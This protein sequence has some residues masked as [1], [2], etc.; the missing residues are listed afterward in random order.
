MPGSNDI[1]SNWF[2][3]GSIAYGPEYGSIAASVLGSVY[4]HVSLSALIKS[5]I[6]IITGEKGSVIHDVQGNV[7]ISTLFG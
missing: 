5:C 3:Y 6:I 2:M 4:Q 7:C 1:Q